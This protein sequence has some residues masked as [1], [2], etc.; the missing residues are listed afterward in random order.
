M[1]QTTKR[2]QGNAGRRIDA[3]M[4]AHVSISSKL[5]PTCRYRQNLTRKVATRKYTGPV[6]GWLRPF[7]RWPRSQQRQPMGP[8]RR[9]PALRCAARPN[10]VCFLIQSM[11]VS[12]AV[13]NSSAFASNRVGSSKKTRFNRCSTIGVAS[14]STRRHTIGARSR[15]TCASRQRAR[16]YRGT[17]SDLAR[18]QSAQR[19]GR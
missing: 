16:P 18:A 17:R 19:G 7:L 4:C 2:K 1:L 12:S 11:S 3:H 5:C 15:R 8:T 9:S 13:A 14:W 10:S 6:P